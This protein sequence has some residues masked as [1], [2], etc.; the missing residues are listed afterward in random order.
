L[1][2]SHK[3]ASV[4]FCENIDLTIELAAVK[5]KRN[6]LL[7]SNSNGFDQEIA[8]TEQLLELS[9]PCGKE[10][11]EDDAKAYAHRL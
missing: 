9:E 1:G 11:T 3:P 8:G 5:I 4:I 10:A 2:R 7:D 6:Q